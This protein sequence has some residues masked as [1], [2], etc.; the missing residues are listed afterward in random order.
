MKPI[1]FKNRLN[2]ELVICTDLKYKKLIDG[3]EYIMVQKPGTSRQYLM[4]KDALIKEDRH[5]SYR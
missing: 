1:F 4:R 2:G 5:S 3:V